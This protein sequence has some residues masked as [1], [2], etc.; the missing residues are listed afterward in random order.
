MAFIRVVLLVM[1]AFNLVVT[2]GE[3]S[4][5]HPT[6]AAK[7]V[8]DMIMKGRYRTRFWL[9]AVLF[10]NVLPI[11]LLAIP[12]MEMLLPAAAVIALIGIYISETIWVEAPQRIQLT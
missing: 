6:N 3:L 10:G 11:V 7:K 4:I 8:A 2:F 1:L 5:T 12:G 9:G